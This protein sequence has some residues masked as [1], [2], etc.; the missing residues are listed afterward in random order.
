[1]TQ[2][3]AAA[4][5]ACQHAGDRSI[6]KNEWEEEEQLGDCHCVS[7]SGPGLGLHTCMRYIALHA[8]LHERRP[9]YPVSLS[10][11]VTAVPPRLLSR[12]IDRHAQISACSPA[13]QD[14]CS[15][16]FTL[17]RSPVL[18]FCSHLLGALLSCIR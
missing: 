13:A 11:T 2:L 9:G 10:A 15:K 1:M 18:S 14:R 6:E 8:A 17:P 7:V 5:A 12:S 4:C 16:S 3:S